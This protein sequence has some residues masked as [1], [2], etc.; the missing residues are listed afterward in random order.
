MRKL[1]FLLLL[2]GLLPYANAQQKV[3]KKGFMDDKTLFE[4]LTNMKKKTDKFNLFLN[5]QGSFD[6]NFRDGLDNGS[7]KMRQLRI[8]AKGQITPWLSYRY[9]QRLNRS[10][11]GSG[12]MDNVPTSIDYAMI[13][14]KPI[15]DLTFNIGKQ[16]AAYGGIE[17]DLNPIEIYEYSDMI[18]NMSNFM[19]GLNTIYDLTPTQQLQLQILNS[20]NGS[21]ESTYGVSPDIRP[22][23]LPLVYTLNWNGSFSDVFKTRWSASA[24]SEAKDK[25]LYYLAFGNELT[26]DKFNMFVDV[27][28]SSED[29]DREGVITSIVPKDMLGNEETGYHHAFDTRYLSLVA[30]LNYRFLPKWNVFVKG[31]YETASVAK[32]NEGIEKGKYRTSWG[33]LAGIEYYPMKTNLHFFLTYVGRSYDFTNKAEAFGSSNYNTNRLSLGFIYQLPVF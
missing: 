33:Y 30:K 7:F 1:M 23:K 2:V 4:E 32:A 15:E 20:R 18:D 17:F 10:N 31:M 22:S 14:V 5:M 29:I 6:L 3:E 8:E 12:M 21:M 28:Y 13:G 16:C 25:W 26:L 9:R 24:M 19:T 27:M 11:D